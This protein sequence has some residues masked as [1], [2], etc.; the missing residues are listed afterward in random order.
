MARHRY[1][2][3]SN[4]IV[5][6]VYGATGRISVHGNVYPI[7]RALVG[8]HVALEPLTA[9][10]WRIWFGDVDL[11]PLELSPSKPELDQA[12]QHFLDSRSKS[13]PKKARKRQAKK[14]EDEDNN[15]KNV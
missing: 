5:R 1:V 6:R 15:D 7:G 10:Q 11:G 3:P 9:L 13:K 4:W 8:Y 12:C 2:Y 14:K